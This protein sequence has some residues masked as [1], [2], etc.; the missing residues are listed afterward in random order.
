MRNQDNSDISVVVV[1]LGYVGLTLA[2]HLASRGL[3]VHGVEIRDGVIDLLDIDKA[4]FFEP[5]LD[6]LLTKVKKAGHFSYSKE[7]PVH[8]NNRVFIIT[9]GTPLGIDGRANMSPISAAATQV[10][11]ALLEN[12]LVVLRSTVKIG[13][14][15]DIVR[16][17][18]Q[19]KTSNFSLA[20]APERTLE[21]S[22]L[23]E[24][25]ELPQIIGAEDEKSSSE[26]AE[27]FG[28]VTKTVIQVSSTK[29]AEMIKL[30]DNM[31][32][33]ARFA[34]SN[35]VASIANQVG[36]SAKEVISSGKIGYPRTNLPMPGPVGGPCLEK[37]SYILAESSGKENESQ[38]LS[39]NAR[40]V[41]ESVIKIGAQI[42]L[43]N[44]YKNKGSE[45]ATVAVIGMAFKGQ[46][47][48]DD[49]RG[50]PS[51]EF[52][53]EL[54]N[55]ESK[56]KIRVWD[57]VAKQ[58]QSG[59]KNYSWCATFQEAITGTDIVVLMNNHPFLSSLDLQ[60]VS[61]QMATDGLIFDFWDRYDNFS[62]MR[63]DVSY[64]AWG[65]T[66][67]QGNKYR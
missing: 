9:V 58:D 31:Q 57:P 12:D 18:L 60:F 26:A 2:V 5:N 66:S 35:E 25:G 47:E 67:I 23:A 62:H 45:N 16:P 11:K 52:I 32:R 22:A 24:L 46:P 55:V 61:E 29:T 56:I 59:E 51:L 4:F 21:G 15:Q 43:A 53:N 33:D 13:T 17:I 30:V 44:K 1:G 14:T 27:F 40:K 3:K 7:I 34:I 64:L 28:R 54:L 48:T 37:D 50:S 6:N 10:S 36:V 41:N 38:S 65:N 49:L 8:D 39:I 63:K 20:F 19:N 42:I